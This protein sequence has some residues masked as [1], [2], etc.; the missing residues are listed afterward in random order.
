MC[1]KYYFHFKRFLSSKHFWVFSLLIVYADCLYSQKISLD[2]RHS[3]LA[4]TFAEIQKQSELMFIFDES[5]VYNIA[6]DIKITGDNTEEIIQK[7]SG[8][9]GF[10]YK[11]IDQTVT[12]FP[13][14]SSHSKT[15]QELT[16]RVGIKSKEKTQNE[17]IEGVSISVVG[18]NR[19]TQSDSNG[20]FRLHV[21]NGEELKYSYL[22]YNPIKI[23]VRNNF[24]P[25]VILNQ[26]SDV[27][28]EVIVSGYGVREHKANQIGS[29]FTLTAKD[30][31][32]KP[33]DRIDRVLEG[34]VP[35]YEVESQDQS[36]SSVRPRYRVRVRGEASAPNGVSSN[37]P[38]WILDGV[39][40]YTGGTTNMM[41]GVQISVSPLSY[42]NPNDIESIV[43]MKDA[44]AT[45]LYGANGANGVIYI[46]TKKGSQQSR[47]NYQYR[48]GLNKITGK[49][50]QVLNGPEYN[51]ILSEMGLDQYMYDHNTDW[52]DVYFRNAYSHS[53]SASFS[54]QS[55]GVRHFVSGS[56]YSED[57]TVIANKTNRYNGRVNLDKDFGSRLNLSL[58]TGGSYTI[59]DI[60]NPGS[61][62]YTNRPTISPYNQ[63]GTY[64]LR[65]PEGKRLMNSLAE[66][67]QNDYAQSTFS[68]NGNIAARIKI[69][70]GLSFTSRNGI[71]Y[72][73]SLEDQYNSMKNLSG[74]SSNG[75]A[76]RA[77]S[78]VRKWISSNTFNYDMQIGD[79]QFDA[80]LGME[81]NETQRQSSEASGSG[82]A[83]D[84]IREV[85][86]ASDESRKGSGSSSDL[87]SLS[88]FGRVSYVWDHKY[89][90]NASFRKDGDSNFGSDVKW[91]TFSS[92]GASWTVSKERFWN[93][94]FIDFLKLKTSYG[95]NGNSRFNGNYSKGIY[96]FNSDYSYGG[97]S[98]AVMTRG[99]NDKL[100][101]ETTRMFNTGIDIHILNS[102]TLALEYYRNHTV[103]LINNSIVSFTSGQRRIY[104]NEGEMENKGV[105]LT[106]ETK[107]IDK[108]DFSWSTSFNFSAN[109][110]RVLKLAEGKDIVGTTSIMREGYHPR[111]F[112]LIQWAG[113]D[114]RDGYPLWYDINGDITRV[115]DPNNRVIVGNPSPDFYGGFSNTIRYKGL[116]LYIQFIYNYGGY[117]FSSLRRNSES[118]GLN[119]LS[120]NQSKNILDH[121]KQPGDLAL[122]PGLSTITRSSSMN[123]TRF[124]HDKTHIRLKNI[125]LTYQIKNNWTDHIKL[126]NLSVYLQG[127]DLGFWTPYRTKKDRNGYENSFDSW[128]ITQ[129]YSLGLIV[130]F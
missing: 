33:L 55:N 115:Y 84:H 94:D 49:R 103:N 13:P 24:I 39:P 42:L 40:L 37:E 32:K 87:S 56:L 116:S 92:I 89:A 81:A 114:P 118:D 43:V 6:A 125:S 110:N 107:N 11:I 73:F 101:W 121:W 122:S 10:H 113:V 60:F 35:G 18:S 23:T 90:I 80:L 100:K 117:A 26:R 21:D 95:T 45:T 127:D 61:Y 64:A 2:L 19:R 51:S 65:D 112:Y 30:L 106:L 17:Y 59:N 34:L 38:L 123:S 96:S 62:Y 9:Y 120:E 105:E 74:S 126:S 53:H 67:Y 72:S 48:F 41:P 129:T 102:F 54:G 97:N 52:Y 75:Y 130:G 4:N 79:G 69:L 50:F 3:S 77:Q 28:E 63:D 104:Q 36:N 66:A 76:R 93:S 128:P 31:E 78:I 124:L 111:S 99:V 109:K 71:D 88:Y 82:F 5:A 57:K 29:A 58:N 46:T 68:F 22:G 85:S 70:Q 12:L 44:S 14:P 98:G 119:I 8:I 20:H 15:T 25:P 108:V 1:V 7:L 91:A 16:G 83:H 27:I 86:Y 47:V